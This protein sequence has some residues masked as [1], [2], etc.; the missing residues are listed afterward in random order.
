MNEKGKIQVAE[1][2]Q[3]S[4]KPFVSYDGADEQGTRAEVMVNVGVGTVKEIE[5]GEKGKSA[6]IKVAVEGLRFPINCFF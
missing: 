2:Q 5:R 1:T 4:Q 6:K 3:Y